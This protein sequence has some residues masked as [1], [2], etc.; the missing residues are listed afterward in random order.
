MALPLLL[1][2]STDLLN[3]SSNILPPIQY[4]IFDQ[5]TDNRVV[6]SISGTNAVPGP[7]KRYVLDAAS[8]MAL[9]GGICSG[10]RNAGND[11]RL[12]YATPTI[13]RVPGTFAVCKKAEVNGRSQWGFVRDLGNVILE[14]VFHGGVTNAFP[15]SDLGGAS[16]LNV[17]AK[18]G[19]T[20]YQEIV[21]LRQSGAFFFVKGGIYTNL[22]LLFAGKSSA[23]SPLFLGHTVNTNTY[24]VDEIYVPSNRFILP[25]PIASDGMSNVS[26][27]DGLGHAEGIVGGLGSGGSG[28]SWTNQN[29]TWQVAGGTRSASVLVSGT[30]I[31]TIDGGKAD[32]Y[33]SIEATRTTGS[34][35]IVSRWANNLNYLYA[36]HDG[37]GSAIVRQVVNGVDTQLLA[38]TASGYSAGAEMV[39]VC[40]GNK[41]RLFYNNLAVGAE[42][43][44]SA[45]LLSGTGLGLY[46]TNGAN[47]FDDMYAYARGT[48]GEYENFFT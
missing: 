2:T 1:F 34:F 26:V 7:G 4:Q 29:G 17:G 31:C 10:T 3:G 16:V 21:N 11:P 14:D 45:S 9:S 38:P 20:Y 28:K 22:T 46:T 44:I 5:Y 43:T 19:N 25:I 30:A 41:L 24:V 23:Q 32:S 12:N 13:N 33:F 48:E 6:G 8:L 18:V 39:L 42:Q 47:T 35:G 36:V 40:Y 15:V 27:T 37:T